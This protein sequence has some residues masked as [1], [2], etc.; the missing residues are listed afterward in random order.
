MTKRNRSISKSDLHAFAEWKI[1]RGRQVIEVAKGK[2]DQDH[3]VVWSTMW[4]GECPIK[5]SHGYPEIIAPITEME[6]ATSFGE[7]VREVRRF[8]KFT[9]REL[10]NALG[11]KQASVSK[12]ETNRSIPDV[13]TSVLLS[14]LSG[15]SWDILLNGPSIQKIIS[16]SPGN[17]LKQIYDDPVYIKYTLQSDDIVKKIDEDESSNIQ[18]KRPREGIPFGVD[19]VLIESN[20][21]H[22]PLRDGWVLFISRV[23]IGAV[24]S[25]EDMMGLDGKLCVIELRDSGHLLLKDIAAHEIDGKVFLL[26]N[27]LTGSSVLVSSDEVEWA[28]PVVSI[29]P[30]P[31]EN[32]F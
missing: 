5:D 14:N 26:L 16:G 8:F 1:K 2:I 15:V 7:R 25:G 22:F 13:E 6:G 20:N 24:Y 30:G 21:A 4:Y 27:S 29:R 11:V 32:F 23:D 3:F 10:A 12:W 9:Q 17:S 19:G 18:V 31:D 28:S